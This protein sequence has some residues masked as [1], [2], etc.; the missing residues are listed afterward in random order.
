MFFNTVIQSLSRGVYIY[1]QALSLKL[2][3]NN[4]FI[5]DQKISFKT[6]DGAEVAFERI[7][8]AHRKNCETGFKNGTLVIDLDA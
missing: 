6:S 5:N 4:I 7:C 3:E 1:T 8:N 2:A